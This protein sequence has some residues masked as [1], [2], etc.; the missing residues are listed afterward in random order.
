MPLNDHSKL[1]VGK[2]Q[3]IL[4]RPFGV[5]TSSKKLTKFFQGFCPRGQIQRIRALYATYWMI[6]F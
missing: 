2:G 6:L 4:K 3:L 1:I 5:K